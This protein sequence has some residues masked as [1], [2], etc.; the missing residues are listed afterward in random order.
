MASYLDDDPTLVSGRNAVALANLKRNALAALPNFGSAYSTGQSVGAGMRYAGNAVSDA[1]SSVSRFANAA[2]APISTTLGVFKQPAAQFG[3]GIL[4]MDDVPAATSNA[5]NAASPTP[6][7]VADTTAGM[8]WPRASPPSNSVRV[9]EQAGPPDAARNPNQAWTMP[10]GTQS[11]YYQQSETPGTARNVYSDNEPH[12]GSVMSVPRESMMAL[13]PETSRALY[14]AK[15]AAVDRGDTDFLSGNGGGGGWTM[16]AS[17]LGDAHPFDAEIQRLSGS[18]GLVDQ[19]K[20]RRLQRARDADLNVR[21]A[22]QN[23][24]SSSVSA[25]AS[26]TR[27]RNE[28]PLAQLH[29]A[30]A[31]AGQGLVY[32]AH[33]MTDATTRAGQESIAR[34]AAAANET[35]RRA[36][37]AA[38]AHYAGEATIRTQ[39]AKYAALNTPEGDA[40][41]RELYELTIPRFQA[42]PRFDTVRPDGLGGLI[43]SGPNG[44]T[45]QSA[46]EVQAEAKKRMQDAAAKRAK[47]GWPTMSG[48]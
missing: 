28:V 26:S 25:Q 40:R 35:H 14:A 13:S 43:T 24:Q 2:A 30:T 12:Y 29:D 21:A 45:A 48:P 23:A 18:D 27:A 31:R 3:R 38:F 6:T 5:V 19:W 41:A 10:D 37:D 9:Q 17:T 4:G 46:A 8:Q 20:G 39:A 11:G 44:V 33:A 47:D 42:D 15:S 34:T 36:T 1:A 16:P 32:G 22:L 7:S